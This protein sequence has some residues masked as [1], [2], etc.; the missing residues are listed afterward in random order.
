[1]RWTCF[2]SFCIPFF[3]PLTHN[4]LSAAQ[5]RTERAAARERELKK[6]GNVRQGLVL[7]RD[8]L[9]DH[10]KLMVRAFQGGKFAQGQEHIVDSLDRIIAEINSS[11]VEPEEETAKKQPPYVSSCFLRVREGS[12]GR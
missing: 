4:P 1:L 10:K 8:K 11:L 5:D 9:M 12:G 3:L 7:R 6:L 2:S